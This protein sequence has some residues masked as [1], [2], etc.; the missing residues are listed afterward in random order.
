LEVGLMIDVEIYY[1]EAVIAP[2]VLIG[3]FL[4]VRAVIRLIPF[5]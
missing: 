2:M 5:V 1:H 4:L 3:L